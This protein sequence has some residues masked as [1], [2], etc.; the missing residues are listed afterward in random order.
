MPKHLCQTCRSN[1]QTNHI[2]IDLFKIL[3]LDQEIKLNA[4]IQKLEQGM[5][6]PKIPTSSQED[7]SIKQEENKMALF[8]E[9]DLKASSSE[10]FEEEIEKEKMSKYIQ[11]LLMQ[12][13]L[14]KEIQNYNIRNNLVI[15]NATDINGMRKDKNYYMSLIPSIH[16]NS[17]IQIVKYKD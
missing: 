11:S 12:Y 3:D 1:H 2:I 6:K 8:S 15:N 10:Q 7:F 5:T 9:E 4:N 17:K 13:I 14:T 16:I